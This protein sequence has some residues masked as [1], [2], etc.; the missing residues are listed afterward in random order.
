MNQALGLSAG[1]AM[2]RCQPNLYPPQ[3]LCNN[4]RHCIGRVART[5]A[6]PG[7]QPASGSLLP[8][9]HHMLHQPHQLLH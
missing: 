5:H 7:G 8:V 2:P 9:C 3:L 6:P 4:L 1:A